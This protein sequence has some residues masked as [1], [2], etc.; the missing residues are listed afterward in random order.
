M[1]DSCFHH[2]SYKVVEADIIE[3]SR[4]ITHAK[5]YRGVGIR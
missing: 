4:C 2:T 3:E 5:T 1:V